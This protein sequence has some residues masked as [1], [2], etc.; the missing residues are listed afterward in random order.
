MV[1]PKK[2]KIFFEIND[3]L[4]NLSIKHVAV[5][6][7]LN[8]HKDPMAYKNIHSSFIHNCQKMEPTQTPINSTMNQLWLTHARQHHIQLQREQT[9]GT[10]EDKGE[11]PGNTEQ[12]KPDTKSTC[13]WL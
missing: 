6:V 13:V 9:T 10:G 8:F 1:Q 12:E 7:Y 2:K 3:F 4:K 11:P 5:I